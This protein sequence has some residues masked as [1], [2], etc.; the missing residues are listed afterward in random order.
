MRTLRANTILF[1][2]A[3]FLLLWEWMRPLETIGGIHNMP[4]FLVF[5][6]LCFLFFLFRVPFLVQLAAGSVYIFYVL[7]RTF[8]HEP[9]FTFQWVGWFVQDVAANVKILFRREWTGQSDSFRTLEFFLLI[10]LMV[11]LLHYW[12]VVRKK[13]LFFLLMTILYIAVFDTF[14]P[15]DGKWPMIRTVVF[16]LFSMGMLF[17]DRCAEREGVRLKAGLKA[18]W[19][20]SL[21]VLVF[22]STAVAYIMPKAD[23]IWPDPVPY[24]QSLSGDGGPGKGKGMSR[25]GYDPDDLFLGGPFAQD[26][27]LVFRVK[28]PMRNYWVVETKDYYTGKGWATGK[29]DQIVYFSGS[30][31]VRDI[32]SAELVSQKSLPIYTSVLQRRYEIHRA[33]I[34]A[35]PTYY[36]HIIYPRGFEYFDFS[37][38]VFGFNQTT[39]KVVAGFEDDYTVGYREPVYEIDKLRA[40]NDESGVNSFRSSREGFEFLFRYTQL[41]ENLPRRV[42]DLAA[43]ITAPYDNWYDKAKAIEQYLK[44]PEFTYDTA[45]VPFPDVDEDYVDQFLFESKTGYCDNFSTAMVVLLRSVGIPARWVK[46]YSSGE[47]VDTEEGGIGVYEL[48]NSHA[49]SWPEVYFPEVGWVPFEPTK[50]FTN[51]ANFVYSQENAGSDTP[52]PEEE[53]TPQQ[54]RPN[55]RNNVPEQG[56]DNSA[57]ENG[58]RKGTDLS[59]WMKEHL[60]SLIASG[61]ALLLAAFLTYKFRRKWLPFWYVARYGRKTDAKNFAGAYLALLKQ[62]E[63]SGM[64]KDE[65]E[66]LRQYAARIDRYFST[67][68]M[69]RLTRL[70]ERV[71]YYPPASFDASAEWQLSW[72]R[73][74]KILR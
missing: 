73:L 2:A 51:P 61:I 11:Y 67:G 20:F 57:A 9:F 3:G 33:K 64:K 8:V 4:V 40:V 16:G 70:Y 47:L 49:H 5:T 21:A 72:R 55:E 69:E 56:P 19:A 50:G 35:F 52:E 29:A 60:F 28:T 17:L 22:F 26:E 10:W 36:P 24:I 62:L 25:V 44:G 58:G 66:S 6:G 15:Y 71:V 14:M 43:E 23:P 46:G 34:K 31:T 12:F 38:G 41:P 63:R 48:K 53:Q 74:L 54:N 30:P 65:G 45:D 32:A 68:D 1:C 27:G 7:N 13:I 59:E 37:G 18:K 39:E 42:T